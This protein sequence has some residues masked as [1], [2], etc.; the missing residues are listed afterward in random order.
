VLS[1]LEGGQWGLAYLPRKYRSIIEQALSS[2][3][4][5]KKNCIW[6]PDELDSFADY[7]TETILSES[8]LKG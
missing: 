5:K 7:M 4:G 3:Q 1:K 2:Y 8:K 6:D